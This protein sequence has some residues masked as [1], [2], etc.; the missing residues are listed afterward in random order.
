MTGHPTDRAIFLDRDG[1]LVH[2]RHYPSR[3][4]E[5]ILYDDL[6]P[7]LRAFQA[8]GFRLVVITNQ[9]GLARGLFTADDLRLM[10]DHLARELARSDVRLDG[11]YHCPHHPDGTVPELAIRCDCRKPQPGMLLQ[12]ASDL[13]L[14]L[15]GSWFIGDILDDCEAGNRAGCRTVLVD[16]GTESSPASPIRTP[17]FVARDTRH[18]LQLIRGIEGIGATADLHYRPRSWASAV[19][20]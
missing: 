13:G 10:H 5:L 3:P 20:S 17:T 15:G 18:A 4:E 6:G 19:G 7:E 8:A 1:T 14:D 2:A 9:S 12:A 16:L 11:V